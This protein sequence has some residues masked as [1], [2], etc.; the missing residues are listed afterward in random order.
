MFPQN[1]LQPV[2]D[3]VWHNQHTSFYPEFWSNHGIVEKPDIS[4]DGT[5][6]T[7]PF[8][9]RHTLADHT[10]DMNLVHV[11]YG[12]L[13]QLRMT[14][15]TTGAPLLAWRSFIPDLYRFSYTQ[16]AGATRL[17]NL[18]LTNNIRITLSAHKTGFHSIP[19]NPKDLEYSCMLVKQLG[20]DALL[21]T[22]TLAIVFAEYLRKVNRIDDIKAIM[23]QSEFCQE[24]QYSQI[25]ECYPNAKIVISYGSTE[26]NQLIGHATE[27]CSSP[28]NLFHIA[29]DYFYTETLA[30]ELIYTSL[31]LPQATPLIR[32]K[33]GDQVTLLE[34]ECSCGRT[35]LCLQ[36]EGRIQH[37]IVSVAG[38]QVRVDELDRVIHELTPLI[39][40]IYRLQ[41]NLSTKI[42][43][44]AL[45]V[46]TDSTL[47][48]ADLEE[49][50][51]KTFRKLRLTPTYTYAD[52][53]HKGLLP[54]PKIVINDSSID[55][56]AWKQKR[57]D[58]TYG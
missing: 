1:K 13:D 5:W 44:V 53:E 21:C 10:S 33:T 46:I 20:I 39:R 27:S 29:T 49:E 4:T 9:D 2:I 18:H 57:I 58:V 51:Y 14:S 45:Y 24:Q 11:P 26:S 54:R 25:R 48:T 47:A 56:S 16:Q 38:G 42:P 15:G 23:L 41:L 6:N 34:H 43:T 22:P 7:I 40:P 17:L 12:S 55:L 37:D 3:F 35:D 8:L 28:H 50:V 19:G 31:S 36:I 52:A 32:Y 30:N